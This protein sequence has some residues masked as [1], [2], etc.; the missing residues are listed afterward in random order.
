MKSLLH[1]KKD[2]VC[3]SSGR[4]GEREGGK[5]KGYAKW[6]EK[7]EIWANEKLNFIKFYF[8]KF[9]YFNFIK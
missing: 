4:E 9:Y 8:I 7:F 1:L 6:G 5:N 3:V 2:N